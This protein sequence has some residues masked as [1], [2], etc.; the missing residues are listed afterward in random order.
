LECWGL[1]A[2]RYKIPVISVKAIECMDEVER[3]NYWDGVRSYSFG[4]GIL[5]ELKQYNNDE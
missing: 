3:D 1:V 5:E 2:R 4:H